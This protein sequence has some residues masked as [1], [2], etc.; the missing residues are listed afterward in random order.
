MI[1]AVLNRTSQSFQGFTSQPGQELWA[2]HVAAANLT[3]APFIIDVTQQHG[4]HEDPDDDDVHGIHGIDGYH[5]D[6]SES[7][8][9]IW[10]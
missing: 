10:I 9:Q 5:T 1:R 7:I 4:D 8:T 6:K 3:S 2:H